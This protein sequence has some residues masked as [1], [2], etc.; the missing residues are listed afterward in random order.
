MF[1]N[2]HKCDFTLAGVTVD[3]FNGHLSIVFNPALATQDVM[4]A[5]R[6][7]VPFVVIPKAGKFTHILNMS[8]KRASSL[9]LTLTVQNVHSVIDTYVTHTHIK[10][11]PTCKQ[12]PT[13]TEYRSKGLTQVV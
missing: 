4:N 12:T 9:V 7:F 8:K 10:H 1:S 6:H 3:V 13:H 11:S 2:L 5:G